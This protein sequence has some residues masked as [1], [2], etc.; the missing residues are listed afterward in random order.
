M[1]T[2]SPAFAENIR[3]KVLSPI[4][5]RYFLH[6]LPAGNPVWG[7]CRFSF[8]PEDRDYDWLVVYEDLRTANKEGKRGLQ[9]T[10]AC[11]A[12]HTMLITSEPSSIKHYGNAYVGQFGCVLTSQETW[13][14]PHPDRIF[15]QAG[16]IWIYG[17]GAD[18]VMSFDH[19]VAHPPMEKTRDLSMVFSPKTMRHTLHRQRNEF[20]RQLMDLMPEME[21]FGHGARPLDDKAEALDPYRYHIA[22]EN[23]IGLHHWTEK[24]A[25]AFLGLTLPFYCGCPNAA[26]YFPPESFIPIDMKDPVGAARIIRQA[27]RDNE[28]EKRLPAIREARRRVLFEHNLF[29]VVSREIGKRHLATAHTPNGG[30]IYSRHALR[31][32]SLSHGLRDMY[33]KARARAIHLLRGL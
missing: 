12:R 17:V 22:I 31:K 15:S 23:Y 26:D 11:P 16:L 2:E 21:V 27:I 32:K 20:M 5:Q 6:Q 8:D 14:L 28:F 13:A 1:T 29:A 25:D 7:N 10:L 3:V 4:P 9:E 18:R 30:I 24:L 19:M 33:G